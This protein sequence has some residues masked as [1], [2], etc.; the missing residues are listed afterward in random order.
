MY[1]Q[2]TIFIELGN[3]L[4]RHYCNDT[5][6]SVTGITKMGFRD[7]L[8]P[9]I[10]S[11]WD[12]DYALIPDEQTFYRAFRSKA[13]AEMLEKMALLYYA[14]TDPAI[15]ELMNKAYADIAKERRL[16]VYPFWS[17]YLKESGLEPNRPSQKANN[18]NALEMEL[19]K[20]R[21]EMEHA[22]SLLRDAI[23]T[24]R[25]KD[26]LIEKQFALLHQ[27]RVA[28]DSRVRQLEE[29]VKRFINMKPQPTAE[30]KIAEKHFVAGNY[31]AY[32]K[33]LDNGI[34]EDAKTVAQTY[35][36]KAKGFEAT[37]QY[38]QALEAYEM[39]RRLQP[40]NA[41]YMNALGHFLH[42]MTDYK[43]ALAILSKAFSL[44]GRKPDQ[45][46]LRAAILN[47]IGEVY[48]EKDD[49]NTAIKHFEQSLT[50]NLTLADH[51]SDIVVHNLNNLGLAW[52]DKASYGKAMGFYNQA[53]GILKRRRE[54]YHPQTATL[55][56][57]MGLCLRNMG[58]FAGAIKKFNAAIKMEEHV[59]GR[60]H[61]HVANYLNNI[62]EIWRQQS[63]Y[64]AA[65]KN[66]EEAIAIYRT[67]F[68]NGHPKIAGFLNNLGAAWKEKGEGLKGIGFYKQAL[69]LNR[70]LFGAYNVSIGHNYNN[71][72]LA[73]HEL[74]E[75]KKALESYQKAL[76]V[77]QKIYKGHHPDIARA[78]ANMGGVYHDKKMFS[79]ALHCYDLSR[80]MYEEY[81]S[82]RGSQAFPIAN[83]ARVYDEQGE[84]DKAIDNYNIAL[85]HFIKAFGTSSMNAAHVYNNLGQTWLSKGNKIES[86]KY[87]KKA[88]A[89]FME[90]VGPK[91]M[92]TLKCRRELDAIK[93]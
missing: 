30:F 21:M 7:G 22:N 6:Q 79:K 5:I 16:Y 72:G 75:N 59:Y 64:D 10:R 92:Y 37:L 67:L 48:L 87:Y 27:Q 9:S 85:K 36:L 24:A 1:Q 62:A 83:M 91:N 77:Y 3:A 33:A 68:K 32:Q 88:L 90:V 57:H 74:R 12:L 23:D 65:I 31:N 71:L 8:I 11:A 2:Q 86:V 66:Y 55:L 46:Y 44:V 80:K 76:K 43:G 93:P 81:G 60:N 73:Y 15:A 29:E 52:M 17:R 84:Y 45:K 69:V 82:D 39:S 40:Q 28:G 50:I 78:Y 51:E 25:K 42:I 19:R 20:A 54:K 56:S 70:K 63:K 41:E 4:L 14:K 58:D 35:Y 47:N 49:F 13:S 89:L 61:P 38:Q 53:F 26:E 18:D 34:K